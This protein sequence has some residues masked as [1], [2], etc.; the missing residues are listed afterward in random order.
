M[1]T[2]AT[3]LSPFTE[4]PLPP[5]RRAV[6]KVGSS[7][8]A[9]D[10]GGLSPRFALGLAQFVSA[11]LAAGRELM[12]VSS[13]AVA[14]GR[15]ILPK[16]AEVGAPIAARQALAAL[17]QAQ[18]IALWQ[19]FFERPVAQ[20]LLTH[21]DLRNRRRYLNA[22]ATLGELLR[23]GALPV[24]NENDTVSVDE[25]KLGDNDN[26]AAIVAA[27]V[28]A[29][30]LFI[31]T[32]IDG[33]YS[34]DPRSNP[35]ARPLDEV[36][37]LTAEVLAMAG[38]S[39]SSVG[40]GG[41]RTKLEAAA[42]AGAAGIETYLFNGRSGEV[43]RALAQDRLHGTRIHAAR[44]RIAA[45]KYWLR[46]APVE[47]GA[48]LVDGGAAAAL[49]DKGASLLPGGVAGAEGDFRRGD[50]VEIRLRDCDGE[51]CL[52]RGVSQYSALDI[53]R[54]ARRHSREIETVLGYS[55][56]ENVVHRDDLVL[57]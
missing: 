46:H 21:D 37:E 29:D 54:I 47:Q 7:L 31:A 23:L 33:L 40:T 39:G 12:I 20:V 8:L 41:M 42:K 17:G 9:A 34:A 44:T 55:Y 43:V 53:R 52:A 27:L 48:I 56:G 25:L 13:G 1:S 15:A 57:L 45:R 6:L 18:L 28:G 3:T 30:A 49:I 19:R 51:R 32:D 36:L 11:N 10:G 14:A 24:I 22:R 50:M 5:W 16:A 35:L 38:G 2:P 4:Q 26:L